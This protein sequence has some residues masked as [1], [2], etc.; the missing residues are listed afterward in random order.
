[1]KQSWID[2]LRLPS[3]RGHP[4]P[5]TASATSCSRRCDVGR[6]ARLT[7]HGL[8][9]MNRALPLEVEFCD[10]HGATRL[11]LRLSMAGHQVTLDVVPHR[12][13]AQMLQDEAGGEPDQMLLILAVRDRAVERVRNA[14]AFTS[15]RGAR[16]PAGSPTQLTITGACAADSTC[17]PRRPGAANLSASNASARRERRCAVSETLSVPRP[18]TA[19]SGH[20]RHRSGSATSGMC[21]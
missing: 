2:R 18:S 9:V 15:R 8:V 12:T 16:V 4:R 17:A 7:E 1:M 11:S 6:Q 20:Q 14:H 3:G 13:V 10:E 21:G 19:A 5:Q